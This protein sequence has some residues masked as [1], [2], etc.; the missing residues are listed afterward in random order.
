MRAMKV[1]LKRVQVIRYQLEYICP[2]CKTNVK[3]HNIEEVYL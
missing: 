1:K 2:S 3:G